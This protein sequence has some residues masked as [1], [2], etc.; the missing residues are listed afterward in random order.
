[1]LQIAISEVRFPKHMKR[2]IDSCMELHKGRILCED[3]LK[4][5]LSLSKKEWNLQI[6]RKIVISLQQINMVHDWRNAILSPF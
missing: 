3:L 5:Y 6:M 4:K 2:L 1:M